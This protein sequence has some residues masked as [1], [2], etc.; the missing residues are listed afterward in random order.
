MLR[1][2]GKTGLGPVCLNSCPGEE[3]SLKFSPEFRY[4]TISKATVRGNIIAERRET[5]THLITRDGSN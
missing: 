2:C 1:R 4:T 5:A 3:G